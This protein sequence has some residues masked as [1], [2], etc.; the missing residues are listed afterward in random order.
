M[1]PEAVVLPRRFGRWED[2]VPAHWRVPLASALAGLLLVAVAF[3]TDWAR[4]ATIAWGSSTFN[5]IL[6]IPPILCWMVAQRASELRDLRPEPWWPGLV[7][8]LGGALVWLLGAFSGLDLARQLGAVA[9][10]VSLVPLLFGVRVSAALLFPMLYAFLL[11]PMGEELVPALQLLT[12]KMTIAMVEGSGIPAL[13]EGVFIDTPAG[14]FEVAEACSGVKF[15]IAMVALG[16]LAA[17]ICFVS[18]KR[19]ILFMAACVVVPILANGVRAFGTIWIAQSVGA[20]RAAGID[21]LIYGWVF[22]ALVVAILLGASWPFFDRSPTAKFTNLERISRS[23]LLAWLE[24]LRIGPLTAIAA[25]MLIAGGASVWARAG[26]ALRADLP[27]E[28][29]LPNVGGWQRVAF[30]GDALAWKPRAEGAERRLVGRYRDAKGNDVD[31]F[32]ALYSSQ[33]DG[34]EPGGFGQGA[35]PPE[36]GWSW[37]SHGPAFADG[38]SE[39][40]RGDTGELRLAVTWYVSGDL[41]TGSN[42]KLKLHSMAD[43]IRLAERPAAM[44]I[45]SSSGKSAVHARQ[46]VEGFMREAGR[47]RQWMDRLGLSE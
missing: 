13:I 47:P 33:G 6:L 8:T 10:L 42:M 30:P 2:Q 38:R 44:L 18:W 26:E 1:P 28:T 24:R 29:A 15:L 46:S 43:K 22:F 37:H 21:H 20:A 25:L 32:L 27:A 40:L 11:V 34:R 3:A 16:L 31:V 19:R 36:S 5:H 7:L 17:N 12:A 9:V 4:I 39:I 41:I 23:P 45:V 14:L 35:M